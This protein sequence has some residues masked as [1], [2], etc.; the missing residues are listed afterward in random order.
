MQ[1][2]SLWTHEDTSPRTSAWGLCLLVSPVPACCAWGIGSICLSTQA[3]DLGDTR[4]VGAYLGD[5]TWAAH[6]GG[7]PGGHT[8]AAHLGGTRGGPPQVILSLTG[9]LLQPQLGSY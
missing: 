9:P 1:L 5:H 2:I 4:G 3:A 8:W 7:I 6:L